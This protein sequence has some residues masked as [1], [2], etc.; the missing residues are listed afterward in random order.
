MKDIMN[1]IREAWMD[2]GGQGL[3]YVDKEKAREIILDCV[4]FALNEKFIYNDDKVDVHT[5]W[6]LV[7]EMKDNLRL[8]YRWRKDK[9][10]SS[11][12][13]AKCEL[14]EFFRRRRNYRTENYRLI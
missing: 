7:W 13:S 8:W 11:N 2:I 10:K 6:R 14:F 9:Y 3:K 12:L 1:T 4:F 5:R